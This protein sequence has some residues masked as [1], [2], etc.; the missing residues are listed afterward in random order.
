LNLFVPIREI[1]RKPI[2]VPQAPV[3]ICGQPRAKV[4]AITMFSGKANIL[5][6]SVKPAKR[7]VV[8]PN[9][10]NIAIIKCFC[11][12]ISSTIKIYVRLPAA[13]TGMKGAKK[14]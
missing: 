11:F 10:A 13:T 7:T 1:S 5:K 4:I 8:F 12:L 6:T 2:I 14:S 3:I 9:G